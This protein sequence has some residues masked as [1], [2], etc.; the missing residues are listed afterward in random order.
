MAFPDSSSVLDKLQSAKKKVDI[1]F[2]I[3]FDKL[4]KVPVNKKNWQLN[5]ASI[6]SGTF[7]DVFPTL[8]SHFVSRVVLERRHPNIL[9]LFS[10]F[11]DRFL[12]TAKVGC[13]IPCPFYSRKPPALTSINRRKSAIDPEIA[14]I[15][16]C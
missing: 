12:A 7:R 10:H 16:V 4:R 5:R 8:C 1:V 11:Q 15:N 6:F 14:S 13:K 9:L 3:V 2:D